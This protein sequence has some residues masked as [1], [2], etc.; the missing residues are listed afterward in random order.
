MLGFLEQVVLVAYIC[1]PLVIS[2][3]SIRHLYN[4][5]G[6][7]PPQKENLI[8]L[9][10]SF[11]RRRCNHHTLEQPLSSLECLSSVIDPKNSRS[12]RNRYV[13]ASQ[14]G[15]V[16]RF[17]REVKW[18]PLVYVKR[19]VMVME[20]MADTSLGVR[21]GAER[22]KFRAGLK[23]R[24]GKRKREDD[25]DERDGKEKV[26]KV[27]EN[28]E[29]KPESKKK[30]VRGPRGPNP[31]SVKKA[32]QVR[33]GVPRLEAD[34]EDAT[35]DVKYATTASTSVD[36]DVNIKEAQTD[37]PENLPAKRKRKRKR[38]HKP[39][40]LKDIAREVEEEQTE[41]PRS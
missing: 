35:Q 23:G 19:S 37:E 17:C 12:N 39:S 22:E 34:Q 14:D 32:K 5:C 41:R 25:D 4:L 3:C 30:K 8:A 10:K 9:A 18:V 1:C 20:P 11:E 27:D 29:A 13:V 26:D 7:P 33:V 38:N 31:L 21:E 40:N 24:G 6:I 16:R 15:D 2:Q 28:D 36:M